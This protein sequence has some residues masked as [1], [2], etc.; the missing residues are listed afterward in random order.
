MIACV[1]TG[2]R[3]PQPQAAPREFTQLIE[4]CWAQE[5]DDRP[6]A[7]DASFGFESLAR[8]LNN[9][10]PLLTAPRGAAALGLSNDA[11][12]V[13]IDASELQF[14]DVLGNGSF[15]LV[16]LAL[17]HGRKVAVK[18][19]LHRSVGLGDD[20]DRLHQRAMLAMHREI[21]RM[22]A[23]PFHEFVVQI[24]GATWLGNGT[25]L[26]AVV[27]FCENGALADAL[28]GPKRRV[29]AMG[30]LLRIAHETASAVRHLHSNGMV[31][32]D[33]AARNV[34][35]ARGDVV[36]VGDFGLARE[37]TDDGGAS[38]GGSS[39]F[40][41]SVRHMAPEQFAESRVFSFASDMFSFGVLLWEIFV[42]E[43]PWAGVSVY[44]LAQQVVDGRR[45]TIPP[46]VPRGVAALMEQCW[47]GDPGA[48]PTVVDAQAQ[49]AK[50]QRDAVASVA[51]TTT[52][53]PAAPTAATSKRYDSVPAEDVYVSIRE[54]NDGF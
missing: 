4:R 42:Q 33:L 30:D 40:A 1:R 20:A 34:L 51:A 3:P 39:S 31:H 36:K 54:L 13:L 26:A 48:R 15:G 11:T 9:L 10:T 46:A 25:E 35:L 37:L 29:W 41:G 2:K 49:L 53:T 45:M 8:S 12:G 50:Q 21:V 22:S 52:T 38:F 27:E 28:Y 19:V 6:S 24:H 18:Q 7:S 43:S 44:L 14:V 23:L 32:R 47:Q 16:H 17:L 5:P